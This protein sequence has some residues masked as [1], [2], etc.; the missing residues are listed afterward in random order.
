MTRWI[1]KLPLRLRSLFRRDRVEREL[2]EELRFHLE[3]LTEENVSKGMTPEEARYAALRELGGVEQI[4][5]E[6]RDMRGVN[7][8]Q[9]LLQDV[10]Y[11][12]R[13]LRRNP[14]FTAAAVGTLA[15]AIGMNATIFS[16]VSL[17]LLKKPPV[18][19][20]DRLMIVA[21]NNRAKGWDLLRVSAPNFESFRRENNVF[22][23]M[24]AAHTGEDFTLTGAGA[25]EHLTGMEVTADYFKI[26]GI[27]PAMGR[28]FLPGEN[29]AGRDRV[30]ILSHALWKQRFGSDRAV[31]GRQIHINDEPYTVIG[32]MP[33]GTD[34]AIAQ[35][36][37]WT[38]IVFSPK[39]LTA[40]AH[41]S[42][43][44][45]V[46]ARLKPGVTVG[47]ASAAV[48]TIAA[49]IAQRDPDAEKGYGASVLSLQKY[50]I[51]AADVQA[52]LA[53][54]M[55]AVI[56]VLLIA[57][58]NIA[59]LLLARAAGRQRE[60]AIRTA[61]GARR[62]RVIRQ[63][64]AESFL[65][66]L[67]GGGLG[68]IL[69]IGGVGLLR[70]P[71]NWN[72]YVAHV[73]ANLHLDGRTVLFSVALTLGA[74]FLFGMVPALRTSKPDLACSL[75][76]GGRTGTEGF[77]RARLR[78]VLVAAEIALSVLLLA[79][80]GLFILGLLAEVRQNAGFNPDH[81]LTAE[82]S[83]SS[84]QYTDNPLKQAG[85][86]QRVTARLQTLPGVASA[87]AT[88]ALPL[89]GWWHRTVGIEGKPDS[90]WP[91]MDVYLVGTKYFKTMEIP[92]IKGRAFSRTD[93]RNS[94]RVALIN[95]AFAQKYFP[96]GDAIGRR[97]FA[98]TRHPAW[99]EIVGIV[100]NVKDFPGQK[101][102]PPQVYEPYLQQPNPY[103]TLVVRT[104]YAPSAFAPRLRRVVWS[105]DKNQ[106][107]E[108]L[109]TMQQVISQSGEGGDVFMSGL[110]TVFAALA[111]LLAAVGIYG[112]IAYSVTQRTHEIGIRMA[113]G[114]QKGDVLALVLRK[115]ALITLIGCAIGF[116]LALPLPKL[117]AAMFNGMPAGGP[118]DLAAIAAV[119]AIVSLLATYLPAR[120]ATKVDPME[121]LRYE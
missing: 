59:G 68:L 33:N 103:M 29:Q 102:N 106:P 1:Y 30:V 111:L 119:V 88:Q 31:I 53:V 37:L 13:Q 80:A 46:F 14:G 74:T 109:M 48:G 49:R 26:L 93:D 6:C 95:R 17:I 110:M 22:E 34:M 7:V 94:P 87:S 63:L 12:L 27:S 35:P 69:A 120:R 112:V 67:A 39:D 58:A 82:I 85:F 79:G 45:L 42:R 62:L 9:D 118:G 20:P 83:L 3:K 8:I 78:G 86:F 16:A 116:A 32:V 47:K 5:E 75:K 56:F 115:G 2:S 96:E 113:L 107:V 91:L 101:E 25:P 52:S 51:Q 43:Y 84:S 70:M 90:E 100:G 72:S 105:V 24:A 10:R 50:L 108:D 114:A 81:I 54:M 61:L 38:P 65:I 15:L 4:K 99:A 89:A 55:G 104:R 41:N 21:S 76:E 40:S 117:F 19:D 28:G 44:L 23:G 77:A 71:L 36:E 57:C 11:G 98:Y 121:A 92:L 97:I 66:A 18:R 60:M 64:L 73:G